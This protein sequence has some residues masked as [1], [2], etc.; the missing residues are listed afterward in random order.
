MTLLL[1]RSGKT[2]IL[3]LFDPDQPALIEQDALDFAIATILSQK[4]EDG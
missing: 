1:F 4:F 3:R 2:P